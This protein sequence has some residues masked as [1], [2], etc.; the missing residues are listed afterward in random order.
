MITLEDRLLEGKV[1]LRL[2]WD[3]LPGPNESLLPYERTV[4]IDSTYSLM[5]EGMLN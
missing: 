3:K 1:Y 4:K 2:V 5:I